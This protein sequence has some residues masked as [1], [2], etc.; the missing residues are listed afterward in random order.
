MRSMILAIVFSSFWL[1]AEDTRAAGPSDL[2]ED[3]TPLTS[4]GQPAGRHV[5][6]IRSKP[7]RIPPAC[8][9]QRRLG[10]D[11]EGR[12]LGA[13]EEGRKLGADEEGRKLGA[14]EEGRKLGADEEGRKLGADEESVRCLYARRQDRIFLFPVRADQVSLPDGSAF[15]RIAYVKPQ[16]VAVSFR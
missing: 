16:V 9:P 1:I 12:K 11:E 6:L 4:S 13:A 5:V 14:A 3:G 10:A 7:F 8:L 15:G 2:S